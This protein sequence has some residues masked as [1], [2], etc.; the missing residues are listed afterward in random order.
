MHGGP[1]VEVGLGGR[2]R[3]RAEKGEYPWKLR[4]V[5]WPYIRHLAKLLT[6]VRYFL[7]RMHFIRY[8]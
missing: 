1:G 4:N 5:Q 2:G 8:M 7:L 6:Q 3:G